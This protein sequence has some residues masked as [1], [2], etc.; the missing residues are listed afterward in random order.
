LQQASPAAFSTN[1]DLTPSYMGR[2]PAYS[3]DH[4]LYQAPS[5][6]MNK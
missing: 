5:G 4:L 6:E 3:K 2:S 1:G